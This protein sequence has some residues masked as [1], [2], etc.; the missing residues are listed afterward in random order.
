[1]RTVIASVAVVAAALSS[2]AGR[3]AA[4]GGA[5]A[6]GSAR[7]PLTGPAARAVPAR[8]LPAPTEMTP[9]VK[10]YCGGCHNAR[11]LKGN[12]SLDSYAVE[13]ASDRLE[14]S[15]KMI[16]KM[17]ADIMPPPGSRR[18]AGDTLE[19]LVETMENVIDK[20]ASTPNPG[21]RGFQRLNRPEYERVVHDLLGVDVNAADFLPLDTKSANFD[22]IADAQALSATLLDGYLNAAASVARVAVGDRKAAPA[23]TTY[24]SS[25]FVSQHP[26][27]HIDGAPY[28]TRGGIVAEHSFPAD[29]LYAFRINVEGG[30]GSRLEDIDVSVDGR[31]V[32]LLHYE[33]GVEE[34][35][36]SADT[37]LGLDNFH[38][39]PIA[40]AAGQHRVSVSFVRRTEGP[41]EDLIKPSEWSLASGGTASAGSTTPPHVIEFAI[42]GPSKVTGLS[43]T[44]SRK[45]IFT[46]HPARAAE[47]APC[48]DRIITRLATRAYRRP[49]TAH[50]REG[51]MSFYKAGSAEGGFES[52]IERALQA[53]L[54]SPWFVFR[55]ETTPANVAPGTDYRISDIELASRLSFFLWGSIP[56]DQLLALAERHRLSEPKTL[57]A[58]VRRMLADPRSEALSTRFASIVQV[59]ATGS[60]VFI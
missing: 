31:Q 21:P 54:A 32:A 2:T 60:W 51:L 5:P 57:N 28:G 58:Q 48:A 24:R 25:P 11:T 52:G 40:I 34:V 4:T 46:C 30:V 8:R 59:S 6:A 12:L 45:L 37:P 50:D 1:M 18:P 39:D 15:E 14:T 35:N 26:W 41:Y 36:A 3:D 13:S 22:N 49:L 47:E 44:V 20:A 19:L 38:T 29:G 55:F 56:D 10:R 27:D 9:V 23:V 42:L 33:K 53:M 43:E 16:R 17:R 7:H